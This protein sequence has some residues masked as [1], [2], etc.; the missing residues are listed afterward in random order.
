MR[1]APLVAGPKQITAVVCLGCHRGMT[2]EYRCGECGW[3]VCDETCGASV[4][5]R[6]ECE[7]L[8][9]SKGKVTF[10]DRSSPN[11]FYQCVTPLRCLWLRERD[12]TRWGV[13]AR[14]E[15]HAEERRGTR[16]FQ[17][18]QRNVVDF[19][20]VVLG[21]EEYDDEVIHAV[22]G[23]LDTNC[24]EIRH[25]RVVVRALYETACIMA[26]EC[27]PNTRHCFDE[28]LNIVVRATVPIKKGEGITTTYIQILINTSA[29]RNHLSFAKCF[30]CD[31][32]RCRDPTEF[33]TYLSG[34]RCL[35]CEEGRVTQSDPLDAESDWRC[36]ACDAGVE[37]PVIR[38]RDASLAGEI[39]AMDKTAECLE[40][41]LVYHSDVL[42]PTSSYM[43]QVKF[44]LVKIY[45]HSQGFSLDGE[46]RVRGGVVVPR[47]SLKSVVGIAMTN[48]NESSPKCCECRWL[49][50]MI[51]HSKNRKSPAN[52]LRNFH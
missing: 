20:R 31:C 8:S 16:L 6:P 30:W 39:K 14:M 7:L 19:I 52:R 11:P 34:W 38:A 4:W 15:S 47:I 36:D 2:S 24:F 49:S 27:R 3:P 42:L 17:M 21:I 25:P 10:G 9:R 40:E 35:Q 32:V 5:H 41:F 1:E 29:R 45:G 28:D 44:A 26:H 33:G 46:S 37:S 22:C 23:V 12:E 48:R 18:R 43:V 13:I 51:S 50:K